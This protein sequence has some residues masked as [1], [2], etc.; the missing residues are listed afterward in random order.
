MNINRLL[1][2]ITKGICPKP[3]KD[4]NETSKISKESFG[5]EKRNDRKYQ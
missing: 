1:V 3:Q 5:F 2:G 4:H